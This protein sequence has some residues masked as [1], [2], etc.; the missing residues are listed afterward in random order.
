[1]F[2]V[3]MRKT[4]M[5]VRTNSQKKK[6][7]SRVSYRYNLINSVIELIYNPPIKDY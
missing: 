7:V 2:E 3:D 6:K 5:G 4:V 1:M